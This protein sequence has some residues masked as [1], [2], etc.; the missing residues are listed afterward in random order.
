MPE[1]NGGVRVWGLINKV[2]YIVIIVLAGWI[3]KTESRVVRLETQ[4]E[5]TIEKINKID[6]TVEKIYD[7]LL[8]GARYG[9]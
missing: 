9:P 5:N 4:R 7:L 8:E 1:N 6:R 3:W 2:A